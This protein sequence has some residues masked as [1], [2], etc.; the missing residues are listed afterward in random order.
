MFCRWC[1]LNDV[2][3]VALR[4]C[5][6]LRAF[7]L[8]GVV[9]MSDTS[10]DCDLS[11]PEDCMQCSAKFFDAFWREIFTI[12]EQDYAAI[13]IYACTCGGEERLRKSREL[14]EEQKRIHREKLAVSDGAMKRLMATKHG[15]RALEEWRAAKRAKQVEKEKKEALLDR[16]FE[17]LIE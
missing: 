9:A 17:T 11:A 16:Y 4:I 13:S 2:L 3:L 8:V 5:S 6:R 10:L 14:E 1:A 12:H 7:G 15:R